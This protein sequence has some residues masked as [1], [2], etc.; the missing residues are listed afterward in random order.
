MLIALPFGRDEVPNRGT[1]RCALNIRCVRRADYLARRP[2][3]LPG[4]LPRTSLGGVPDAQVT[5]MD[6]T[7]MLRR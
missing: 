1:R 7:N 3:S 2:D 4:T 5:T 6:A